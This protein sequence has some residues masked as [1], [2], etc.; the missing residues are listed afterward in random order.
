MGR[1]KKTFVS[2]LILFC[3]FVAASCSYVKKGNAGTSGATWDNND[4]SRNSD[5]DILPGA[6]IWRSDCS[7]RVVDGGWSYRFAYRYH[8]DGSVPEELIP[9]S[10]NVINLRY[11]YSEAVMNSTSSIRPMDG[12]QIYKVNDSDP[13]IAK[14]MQL[15]ADMLGNEKKVKPT[16]EELLA[17]DKD[18]IH[19]EVIDKDVFFEM[20]NEALAKNMPR[21][22]RYYSYPGYSLIAEPLYIDDYRFQVGYRC[23]NGYVKAI[24]I[25]VL[26]KTGDRFNEYVQLYDLVKDGKA[27]EEQKQLN[28]LLAEISDGIVKNND[29]LCNAKNYMD[30]TISGVELKRL[31][32]MLNDIDANSTDKYQN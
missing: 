25:D 11:K 7:V 3:L 31:E 22:D 26:Y 10:F 2:V 27:T 30:K 6:A 18:S 8:L 19:F 4:D 1:M 28:D 21:T 20:M 16:R 13:K 32:K 5:S 15:V 17:I 12:V 9:Y 29:F 24:I 14:D 23:A